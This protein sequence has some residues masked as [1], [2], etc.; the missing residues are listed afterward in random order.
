MPVTDIRLSSASNDWE[1]PRWVFDLYDKVWNFRIDVAASDDNNQCPL[2]FTKE[3]DALTNS[4]CDMLNERGIEDNNPEHGET[5]TAWCNPPYGRKVGRWVEK[6]VL[7]SKHRNVGMLIYART[8][9]SYFH[10]LILPNAYEIHFIKG[11]LKFRNPAGVNGPATAGSMM[12]FFARE[13][14][15]R[16]EFYSVE[17]LEEPRLIGRGSWP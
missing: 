14:Y 13:T 3:D 15:N 17:E 9:T 8:D 4:W 6:C 2:Y 16:P 12:V 11:R 10:D 1:T 5:L 7:E